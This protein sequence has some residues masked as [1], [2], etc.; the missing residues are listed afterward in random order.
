MTICPICKT[1]AAALDKTG[2][3]DGFDCPHHGK[4]KVSGTA[5]TTRQNANRD[6]WEAALKR[7]KAQQPEQWASL[8]RDSDF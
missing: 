6:Q 3:A 8:I 5:M 7:A 4:F 2:E 1:E